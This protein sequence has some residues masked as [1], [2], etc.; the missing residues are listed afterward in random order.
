MN[1]NTLFLPYKKQNYLLYLAFL[2]H[3]TNYKKF[4]V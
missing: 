4:Q 3:D 2:K 1:F